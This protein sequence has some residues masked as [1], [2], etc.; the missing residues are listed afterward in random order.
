[1]TW[2]R[3]VYIRDIE[4]NTRD[5]TSR[6][7]QVARKRPRSSHRYL[8]ILCASTFFLKGG[9]PKESGEREVLSTT[10]IER[11]TYVLYLYK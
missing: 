6:V 11:N 3:R 10:P 8:A 2:S 7:R 9:L 4:D 1:M 5:K